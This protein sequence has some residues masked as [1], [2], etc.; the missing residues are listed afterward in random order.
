MKSGLLR[1]WYERRHWGAGV[2]TKIRPQ[3]AVVLLRRWAVTTSPRPMHKPQP[4][5]PPSH[6]TSLALR[7]WILVRDRPRAKGVGVPLA[8]RRGRSR[9]APTKKRADLGSSCHLGHGS[10]TLVVVKKTRPDVSD[11]KPARRARRQ[12]GGNGFFFGPVDPNTTRGHRQTPPNAASRSSQHAKKSPFCRRGVNHRPFSSGSVSSVTALYPPSPPGGAC[13]VDHARRSSTRWLVPQ[14]G[15][16]H[17]RPKPSNCPI[18]RWSPA[19][20]FGRFVPVKGGSAQGRSWTEHR[21]Q[22][23]VPGL[24]ISYYH[25]ACRRLPLL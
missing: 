21:N 3:P 20:H 25:G 7:R 18:W 13:V 15:V 12:G 17:R 24:F 19:R 9:A 8:S 10:A 23:R 14:P 16:F 2:G 1:A 22:T 4:A 6:R 11:R 5:T